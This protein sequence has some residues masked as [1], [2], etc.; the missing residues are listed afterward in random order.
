LVEFVRYV[1]L[2]S[3]NFKH[4]CLGLAAPV[5]YRIRSQAGRPNGILFGNGMIARVPAQLIEAA[6]NR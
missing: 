2:Q 3:H 4:F 6:V 5:C 1:S